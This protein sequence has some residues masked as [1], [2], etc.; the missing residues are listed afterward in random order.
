[1][2]K[3]YFLDDEEKNRILNLHESATKRQYLSEQGS[4]FNNSRAIVKKGEYGDPYIYAK[5]GDDYYFAKASEGDN[6]KWKLTKNQKSI[7]DIKIKIFNTKTPVIKT[8]TPPVKFKLKPELNPTAIDSTSVGN[9]RDKRLGKIGPSIVKPSDNKDTSSILDINIPLH[10]YAALRFLKFSKTPLTESEI[11]QQTLNDISNILCEKSAR[12]KTCDPSRWRGN[13]P[14]K[15]PNKNSLGYNDYTTLYSKSPS[16]GKPSFTFEEQPS[17][18]KGPML[19]FG[20]ANISGGE[21]GWLISDMYNF[22]NISESKPYLKTNSYF[23]M[24]KNAVR[25]LGRAFMTLFNNKSPV[26]GIEEAMSQLHNMGYLGYE[27]K[28]KIPSNGC[29]CKY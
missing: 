10:Q 29:K 15:N 24:A 4:T 3:L 26:D 22:D 12:M 2:K 9:G 18:I 14:R 5:L 28:V 23:S 1:M 11:N 17:S 13:D 20:K 21:G 16:Y 27:V 25:G 19:T 7:D 8:I 6:P